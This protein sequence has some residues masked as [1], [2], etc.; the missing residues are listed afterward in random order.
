MLDSV[1][2]VV[3]CGNYVEYGKDI[4][5]TILERDYFVADIGLQLARSI[6]VSKSR[7]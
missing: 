4:T 6:Y 2:M 7:P 1:L 3:V 5:G